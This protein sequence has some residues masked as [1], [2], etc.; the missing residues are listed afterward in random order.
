MSDG[1]NA[2]SEGGEDAENEEDQKGEILDLPGAMVKGDLR[3]LVLFGFV[4]FVLGF[5]YRR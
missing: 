4:R 1:E 3:E 5:F 2:E